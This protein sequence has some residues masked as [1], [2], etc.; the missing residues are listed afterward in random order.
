MS[1]K[2]PIFNLLIKSKLKN[3]KKIFV[4]TLG[5]LKT[6]QNKTEKFNINK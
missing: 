3:I 4:E 2:K 1:K 6:Q 5:L